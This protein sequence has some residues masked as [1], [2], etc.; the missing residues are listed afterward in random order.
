MGWM[1]VNPLVRDAMG[2]PNYEQEADRERAIQLR[3]QGITSQE[4]QGIQG[5]AAQSEMERAKNETAQAIE[6]SRAA[7]QV[8]A[9][10]IQ[11]DAYKQRYGYNKGGP[12][13]S[14]RPGPAN[15]RDYAKVR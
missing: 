8:R 12:V 1:P 7:A 6:A 10:Q 5:R 14:M 3:Q 11:A 9:A 4:V 2:L 13:Q 15:T